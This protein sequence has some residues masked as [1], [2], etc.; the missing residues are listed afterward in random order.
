MSHVRSYR[1][2]TTEG[3]M[4]IPMTAIDCVLLRPVSSQWAARREGRDMTSCASIAPI[5]GYRIVLCQRRRKGEPAAM[6]DCSQGCL[7]CLTAAFGTPRG[8]ETARR[9]LRASSTG[10]TRFAS[11]RYDTKL[12]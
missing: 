9:Y 10:K 1:A 11:F 3:A 5:G 12:G 8:G 4:P 6:I 7:A 2:I